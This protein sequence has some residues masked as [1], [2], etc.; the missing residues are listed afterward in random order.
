MAK[1]NL[2]KE[3]I[4]ERLETITRSSRVIGAEGLVVDLEDLVNE[5][6]KDL[7]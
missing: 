7:A 1:P 6:K 5:I 4:I 2:T 3:K